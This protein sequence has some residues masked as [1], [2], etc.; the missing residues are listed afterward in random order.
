MDLDEERPIR[1][2]ALPKPGDTMRRY[3]L[4]KLQRVWRKAWV[5]AMDRQ[6][7]SNEAPK[8]YD[9]LRKKFRKDLV[10][11][12]V[13]AAFAVYCAYLTAWPWLHST[14][15]VQYLPA[16]SPIFAA[17]AIFFA[18]KAFDSARAAV[19]GRRDVREALVD[20]IHGL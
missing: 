11:L 4:W 16:W 8:R 10:Y 15:T 2:L 6:W 3:K 7:I 5:V 20:E 1:D 17:P 14:D 9:G 13:S 12:A 19:R 18:W